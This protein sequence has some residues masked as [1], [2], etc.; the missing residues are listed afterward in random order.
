MKARWCAAAAAL[1]LALVA[2]APAR[3]AD[4][5]PTLSSAAKQQLMLDVIERFVPHAE[6]YWRAS[7]LSEPRS[8]YWV[9]NGPGVTQPRG[10]GNVAMANATLLT[11]RPEQ[12][13]FGGVD[14]AVLLEHTIQGIRHEALTS[15]LSGAGYNRWGGGTWQASLETY[16]WGYAAHLLWDHLDADTRALVERV[17]TGEADILLT[18]EIE[19]GTP[20]NTAAEDAAWN[21]P[22]PALAAVMFPHHANRAAWE[23]RAKR[24][25]MNATA[26]AEDESVGEPVDGLPVSEWMESVN[27]NPDHTL[28]NHGFFNPIYQ[29]VV[30]V[31]IGEAAMIYEQAG[32]AVPEAFSFRTEEIWDGILGPLAADDGDLIMTAGQDWTSKDYQHLDY[33]TVLATR[34]RRADASVAESRALQLVARRQSTHPSGAIIGQPQLGYETVLIKRM[35]AAWWNHELFGPSPQPTAEQYAADRERTGGVKEYPYVDIV[36][37]R[38]RDAFASMSWAGAQAM[39]LVVPSARGHED[40]PI[41]VAYTPRSLVGSASGAVGAHAC[42]CREDFF[43]TAGSIGP[44]RFSMTSF[45]DG[46]TM[47]LDRG[48]GSTFSFG[49][50]R[51]AGLTGERTV[52]SEGGEGLGALP[53]SWANVAD[54]LGLVVAGGGG[55]AARDVSAANPYRL[56]EGSAGTGSGNRGALVLPLADHETTARLAESVLQPE[57]PEDW[58][59]LYGRAADGTGR[60]AVA[61]WGGPAEAEL[62]LRDPRGGPVTTA[63]AT[64]EGQAARGTRALASPAS[65][66]EVVRYLVD[67]Q[68]PVGARALT[69]HRAELVNDGSRAARVT[70]TYVAADGRELTAERVLAAGETAVARVIDGRLIT[71]GPEYEPLREARQ[72]IAALVDALA[73]WRA[74]GTLGAGDATRLTAAAGRVASELD[75]ALDAVAAT[76]PD[77]ARAAQAADVALGHLAQLDGGPKVVAERLAAERAAVGALLERARED[78]LALLVRLDVLDPILPGEDVRVRATVLNRA[79]GAAT[80]AS[81]RLEAPAGWTVA[82]DP[83]PLGTVEPGETRVVVFTL[84]VA[85]D[86]APGA[87]VTLH[88]ALPYRQN[89]ES[90]TATAAAEGTVRPVLTLE[91][92]APAAPLAAGGYGRPELRITNQAT[93]SLTADLSALTAPGISAQP[94]PASIE[95]GPGETRTVAVALRNADRAS[96]TS[97]LTVIARTAGGAEGRATVELRHSGNLALNGLGAPWPAAFAS[98]QQPAYPPSLATDGAP[99]TFWVSD[100]TQRGEGPTPD[101]PKYLGV[102]FGAAVQVGSVRMVPRTNYGPRAYTIEVSDDGASW[103]EVASVPAAANGAVTTSFAPTT[104]RAL[105]LRITDSH[106]AQRP[107]RNVQVAELEVRT[108]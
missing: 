42:D 103:R 48:S 77:T 7:D 25:A 93:R 80:G 67:A 13:S 86:A 37:A 62:E 27:A 4:G 60:L 65:T 11:A 3:A 30:H 82:P 84:A 101:R 9:A 99:G 100:G 21:T 70:V 58:S 96:G 81:L 47:L 95:L 73:A 36:Q 55:L 31:N 29:Q 49:F 38:Q 104:V 59:A 106:D 17:V 74:D 88:A 10:V 78:G 63:A 75:R 85:G 40:D 98:G 18:K 66:G 43:S 6:T 68:A 83:A 97:E 92:L 28:E 41:L 91:P 72:R 61:R 71:A 2:G 24:L 23:E 8:G 69:E 22:A 52:F 107:P 16:G 54:R 1:A 87:G 44:R 19:S 53:G 108:Q 15:R 102:D 33:L 94:E 12:A 32:H 5:P 45:P 79:Q 51:I 35:T 26:R 64:V 90:R 89:G 39:G 56:L 57:V 76:R 46:T 105:R 34:M 20:G 50:E 14:R